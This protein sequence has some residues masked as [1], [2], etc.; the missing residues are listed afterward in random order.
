MQDRGDLEPCPGVGRQKRAGAVPRVVGC[1][2]ERVQR[3]C[4]EDRG[5]WG[6]PSADSSPGIPG[7]QGSEFRGRS[8]GGQGG[9]RPGKEESRRNSVR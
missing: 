7:R 1:L 8:P 3:I 6:P 9:T 4:V 5:R 2:A